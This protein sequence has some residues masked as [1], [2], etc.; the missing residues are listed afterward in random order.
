L[1]VLATFGVIVI[2]VAA[3]ILS[4]YGSI[5]NFDWWIGNIYDSSVRFCIPIFLMISGALILSKTYKSIGEYLKKR[6]L[7]IVLPF[8]FWSMIYIASSL[9]HKF[10]HGEH[11]TIAELITFVFIQLK[12][13]ASF[14]LW[15]VYMIIGLY[16]FFPIIGKWIN[17]SNENEIK[18]FI[19]IWLLAAIASLPFMQKN[20]PGINLTYFSGYI[21][22][23]VLGY[24]LSR[25]TFSNPDREKAISILLILTGILIT[26]FG[27]YFITRNKGFM[28]E[29]FYERLSPNV[30]LVSI[31]IFLLFKNSTKFST[32]TSS[33]I[34]FFSKYS[35]GIYLIHILVL[36]KLGLLG[37]SIFSIN[38]VIGIPVTAMLC[39]II[40][41]LIIFGVNK[42]PWGKYISG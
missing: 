11:M 21:G 14:H 3:G 41:T 2:H 34:L 17:K 15:Y 18:Y 4:Q 26:I 31:G 22:F 38:P 5:I 28:D 37:F 25:K 29:S 16:L 12:K 35:Y 6:A 42:L 40:S 7:R 36:W 39:F 30:I 33:V 32:R 10:Y 23:P 9:F 19:G 27:T 1:R 20:F 13:G 24:Y 8:L